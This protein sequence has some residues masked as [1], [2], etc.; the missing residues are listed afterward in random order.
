MPALERTTCR[1]LAAA[2]RVG[3]LA[4]VTPAGHPHAVP[5]CFAVV[6]DTIVS[7]IDGKPKSTTRLQRIDNLRTH[8]D[9]ALL[10]DHYD[11]DWL[12]LWWVRID[13]HVDIVADHDAGLDAL[14]EKYAQ[15]ADAPPGGPFLVLHPD[16]WT[17]WAYA[18]SE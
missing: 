5:V 8:P 1:D 2:A 14:T 18:R 7:A 6:G 17:G 9:A 11:D 4:T 12:Q 10:V 13:A 15:Y 16:R 3:R